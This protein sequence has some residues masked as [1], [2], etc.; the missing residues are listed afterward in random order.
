M[1]SCTPSVFRQFHGKANLKDPS[2]KSFAVNSFESMTATGMRIHGRYVH[3]GAAR[4]KAG[5]ESTKS[6]TFPKKMYFPTFSPF[7]DVYYIQLRAKLVGCPS[8][9]PS[10]PILLASPIPKSTKR[11]C[12]TSEKTIHSELDPALFDGE[13]SFFST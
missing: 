1:L 7:C 5:Q 3:F 9:L 4:M 13:L 12:Q 2:L 11:S 10:L 6:F 8:K